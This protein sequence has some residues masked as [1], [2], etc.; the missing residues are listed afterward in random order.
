MAMAGLFWITED[1]VYVGAEPTGTAPGVRLT[2]DGVE[3]LGLGEGR[4]WRWD[5]VRGLDV[6]DVAVRTPARRLVTMAFDALLPLLSGDGEQPPAFTVRVETA[7]GASA[8]VSA[9]AAVPG[10]IHT[11]EEYELSRALLARLADGRASVDDL[12]VRHHDLVGGRVR[13]RQERTALL[14][15]WAV[16]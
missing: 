4:A 13:G 16:G 11:P 8:E 6:A 2:K 7:D 12:L 14:R 5:E 15:E 3:T 10:G 9:L 1:C